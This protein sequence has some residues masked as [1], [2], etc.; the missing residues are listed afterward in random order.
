V[1]ADGR[2]EWP[3]RSGAFAGDAI[4]GKPSEA[5]QVGSGSVTHLDEVLADR[6]L[7]EAVKLTNG[8]TVMRSKFE[9]YCKCGIRT[10]WFLRFW[11]KP[12]SRDPKLW[13]ATIAVCSFTCEGW[14]NTMFVAAVA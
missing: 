9:V 1:E 2:C 10:G 7:Y 4:D 13:P 12:E 3:R 5:P 8:D 6:L 14:P 11:G